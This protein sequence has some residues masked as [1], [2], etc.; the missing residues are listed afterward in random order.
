MK[1]L[2]L[3][4]LAACVLA[5]L[6]GCNNRSESNTRI[7][8]QA[9]QLK[10]MRQV[11]RALGPC[12]D[13]EG[14]ENTLFLSKDGSWIMNMVYRGVKSPVSFAYYGTWARTADRLI[15]TD[16]RGHKT[17]FRP[18][19]DNLE[20]LN[21]NGMPMAPGRYTPFKPVVLPLPETP[22][23]MRG[24]YSYSAGSASFI[25]CDTHSQMRVSRNAELERGYLTVRQTPTQ[26]VLVVFRAHFVQA[27]KPDADVS[28]PMIAVDNHIVFKAGK[29]CTDLPLKLIN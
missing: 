24:M 18:Q 15:L 10:P 5:T 17:Y 11:Y 27:L 28:Q 26:T 25:D 29:D 22:M 19:G 2:I 12:G 14:I 13:C 21:D 20:L 3:P 9:A 8:A 4:L 1:K 6:F 16:S 23:T 7:M